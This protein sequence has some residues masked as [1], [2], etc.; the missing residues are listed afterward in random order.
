MDKKHEHYMQLAIDLAK[1]GKEDSNG[2]AF[3]AVI[4]KEDKVLVAVHNGVKEE[5][6]VTQHAE[7]YAI[8]LA[9]KKIGKENLNQCTFYTSCEPCLMCLG[10]CYW[11]NFKAIYFGASAADAKEYGYVYSD[12]YYQMDVKKRHQEFNMIQLMAE[13][14]IKVWQ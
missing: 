13:E 7:L 6:D 2:G 9:S 3:G 11:A 14:A 8:Q 4:V 12:V 1:K 5:G 10:A